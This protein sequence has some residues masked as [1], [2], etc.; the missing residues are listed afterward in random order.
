MVATSFLFFLFFVSLRN[1]EF[2][3]KYHRQVFYVCTAGACFS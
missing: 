1:L 2:S 3:V